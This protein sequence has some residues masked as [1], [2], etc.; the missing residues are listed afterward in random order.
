MASAAG[1]TGSHAHHNGCRT[2]KYLFYC[3]VTRYL[4]ELVS[5]VRGD[6]AAE[7]GV[8]DAGAVGCRARVESEQRLASSDEGV[9]LSEPFE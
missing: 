4:K 9:R 7:E 6:R 5:V 2:P 1:T 3:I 8:D